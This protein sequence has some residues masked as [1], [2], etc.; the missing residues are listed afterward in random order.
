MQ[1]IPLVALN[2]IATEA[3]VDLISGFAYE[4]LAGQ[5]VLEPYDYVWI[6]NKG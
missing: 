4:E 5:I 3:W 2:L 6:T 1:T